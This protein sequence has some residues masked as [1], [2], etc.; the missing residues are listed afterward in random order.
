LAFNTVFF[1]NEHFID[2]ADEKICFNV[3]VT[4]AMSRSVCR[5]IPSARYGSSLEQLAAAWN[6]CQ[7]LGTAA[8]SLEQLS[9]A[10]NSWRHFI[11]AANSWQQFIAATSSWHQMVA[12]GNSWTRQLTKPFSSWQQL[13][14]VCTID[15][16]IFCILFPI[17]L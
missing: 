12:A 2:V 6:S 4:G 3:E 13:A 10:W 17:S 7:Q 14:T 9:A 5:Y 8:S 1:H 11:A 15:P 16:Y